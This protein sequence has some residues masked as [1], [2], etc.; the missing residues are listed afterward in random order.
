MN[1]SKV[2]AKAALISLIKM[3]LRKYISLQL[4]VNQM[5]TDGR[6]LT[7]TSKKKKKKGDCGFCTINELLL[8]MSSYEAIVSEALK[9]SR[10]IFPGEEIDI[11][12]LT[13][14]CAKEAGLFKNK[15]KSENSPFNNNNISIPEDAPQEV[16]DICS[17]I[18]EKLGS[19][20]DIKIEVI[21]MKKGKY[22]LNPEDF[23]D[24]PSFL[25]AMTTA[26][27][28]ERDIQSGDKTAEE[29]LTESM[30][31]NAEESVD[32]TDEKLN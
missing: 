15:V 27:D 3:N 14:E 17:A 8:K 30:L 9:T 28:V 12:L 18:T 5:L 19:K 23:E 25:K 11:D 20:G 21:D 16:H 26:R 7:P 31:H 10:I 22:G 24:F 29:I 4:T 32:R 6:K 1:H 2:Q 13:E